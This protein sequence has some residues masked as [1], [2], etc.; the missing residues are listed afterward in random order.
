MPIPV[1][2]LAEQV[3]IADEVERL[4]SVADETRATVLNDGRRCARLR[5]AVLKS[6]FEG[7]LVDQD[8]NDEPAE[9]LLERI[10]AERGVTGPVR[11]TLH[12]K[13]TAAP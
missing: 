13:A 4:L 6:A 1:P 12:R 3:R 11:R 8:P 10:R 2:P 9:N 7:K 5:Q